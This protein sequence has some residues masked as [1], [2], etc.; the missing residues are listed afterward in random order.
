MPLQALRV[1]LTDQR[2]MTEYLPAEVEQRFLGG[3]GAAA[4]LLAR[5]VP[6]KIGPL[7][8]ANLLIFSAGPL[9]GVTFGGLTV[10][11]RSPI[12]NSVSHG[13]ASGRWGAHLRRAGYDLL[14]LEGQSP[15]WC[16]IR[17]DGSQVDILP[18]T[19]LLGLD[20]QATNQALR[21]DLGDEY[22]VLCIGPA[23][24][25][26]VAYSAIVA[27]GAFAVEPAG[28]GAI[29]ARKR[30]KAIAVRGA[31]PCPVADRQRLDQALESIN[32]RIAASDVAAGF[33]QYGSLYYA[34]RAEE[35]G[36]L[37]ARNG[38]SHTVSHASAI[39]R[40][41]LAQRGR[42]ESRGCEGC[43]LAC[44]SAYIRKNGEPVAYPDLEALAGF[45]WRCG[46][47]APDAIILVNDLCLR[48]GLDVSE[49]SAALAF[50]M[51][52]RERGLIHAGNLAWGDLESVVGA[53][54]RLGQ[55]QEKRDILSLGVGEMQEVYYGSSAFAP[56][57]RQLAFPAL[58]PRALPEIALADA[59][60]PIGGDY[61]YAMIYEPFLVEP[62][63]WL[64]TD[65]SNPHSIQGVV[66]RLI[67]H[68]RFAAAV[69]A[70]GLCRR[71]ALLAYQIAPAELNELLAA[72]LG[73][74]FTSVDVAKIGERIVTLER[75]LAVQY[76]AGR[77]TLPHRWTEEPL[78]DGPAAG[79]LPL[80]NDMLAEYYRRHGWDEQGRPSE[81]RLTELGITLPA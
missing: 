30:V 73:R 63:V 39:S 2:V 45:G 53:L 11:T 44:H 80:L 77:D 9:A 57:V 35:L 15:D 18:A 70:A 26:G 67:W 32:R 79:K 7:A 42:R 50:V 31:H 22:A 34:Q 46:L 12:T 52:C 55:R 60:A 71:L 78:E 14:I 74:S 33:R 40:T 81:A 56:Q 36:A 49:T 69:D 64:P 54:R 16:W 29:M 51:E 23:G 10:T 3:R 6:S 43:L 66:P 20:T 41:A 58:D 28:A 38:Q 62:P 76:G 75:W 68:E 37:S 61:R 65:P 25:A 21:R 19:R 5:W 47:S 17:I 8:P 48:L 4:W 24:E 27:E 59:T 72:T 1:A 13:W